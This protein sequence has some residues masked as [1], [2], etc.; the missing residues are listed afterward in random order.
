MSA[1][2]TL[3]A[4]KQAVSRW[5]GEFSG[6]VVGVGP[7]SNRCRAEWLFD[8]APG[9][10]A[11][12]LHIL[13]EEKGIRR[14]SAAT[15]QVLSMAEYSRKV[16]AQFEEEPA[17]EQQRLR[18]A[19]ARRRSVAR[20]Q[21]TPLDNALGEGDD[22]GADAIPQ[23]P[24]GLAAPPDAP[25]PMH[26]HAVRAALEGTNVESVAQSWRAEHAEAAATLGDFPT[27]VAP[28]ARPC[29]GGCTADL[30]LPEQA[31]GSPGDFKPA[32]AQLL[33]HIQLAVRFATT[34]ANDPHILLRLTASGAAPLGGGDAA[35]SVEEFVLVTGHL[36]DNQDAAFE[37]TG[38]RMERVT[39]MM[40]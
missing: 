36:Y 28:L 2:Y 34:K 20:C 31:D 11:N 14:K 10:G 38:F 7:R 15:G 5:R 25:L 18:N 30:R 29:V 8:R 1:K 40:P 3:A 26:P 19:A 39:A 27:Q 16:K 9:S 17:G 13:A 23:G 24:W 22:D 37:A 12:H 6:G 33:K 35:T 4:F 21:A 32:V